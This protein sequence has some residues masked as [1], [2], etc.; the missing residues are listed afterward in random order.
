MKTNRTL[1]GKLPLIAAVFGTVLFSSCSDDD[2]IETGKSVSVKAV[3]VAE[4]SDSQD[5]YIDGTKVTTVSENGASNYITTTNSGNDRDIEFRT[6]GSSEV[7][8]S[9]DFDLKDG[10]NYT[11]ILSGTGSSARITAREDDLSAPASG[12]AKVRF[13]HLSTATAVNGK[14]DLGVV[15]NNKLASNI[16]YG[17]V[18]NFFEVDAGVKLLNVYA[19]GQSSS[20]VALDFTGLNAGRIYTIILKGSSDVSLEVISHN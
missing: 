3:N 10:K 5:F 18:T 6:T 13:A 20:S 12:K 8:A 14:V 9:D 11:F 7:Y 19:A 17:D 1:F 15:A 4:N 16:A 2:D